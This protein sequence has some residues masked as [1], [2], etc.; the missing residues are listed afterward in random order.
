MVNLNFRQIHEL[1]DFNRSFKGKFIQI[2][3]F[4]NLT[5]SFYQ[6][7]ASSSCKCLCINYNTML[8]SSNLFLLCSEFSHSISEDIEDLK[9]F[10]FDEFISDKDAL[11]FSLSLINL[12]SIHKLTNSFLDETDYSREFVSF[13]Q[14]HMQMFPVNNFFV[15][16]LNQEFS[17]KLPSLNRSTYD[18][19]DFSFGKSSLRFSKI[20]CFWLSPIFTQSKET[21]FSYNP[22]N[23]YIHL[24]SIPSP[25]NLPFFF[26]FVVPGLLSPKSILEIFSKIPDLKTNA[27]TFLWNNL[28]DL[29]EYLNLCCQFVTLFHSKSILLRTNANTF[30][31]DLFMGKAEASSRY[32]QLIS[33]IQTR[34][35][36]LN[37]DNFHTE[38]FPL[39]STSCSHGNFK[40]LT[41]NGFLTKNALIASFV[42]ISKLYFLNFKLTYSQL[43][44]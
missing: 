33:D 37:N 2:S 14:G 16:N 44:E 10:E 29:K 8:S 34:Y 28:N 35:S 4:K 20:D 42:E 40:I 41:L 3:T 12:S 21:L 26:N 1:Y 30:S 11:N 13:I 36:S 39:T 19:V 25:Q 38:L 22:F 7:S 32:L 31:L 17:F 27:C 24:A 6:S 18:L 23:F 5:F 9:D 43:P 15:Y